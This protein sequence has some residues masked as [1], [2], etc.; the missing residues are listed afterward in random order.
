MT[1]H[2]R[3]ESVGFLLALAQV[4]ERIALFP[5]KK[6]QFSTVDT[7]KMKVIFTPER[8]TFQ[9]ILGNKFSNVR[10]AFIFGF[11]EVHS[12]SA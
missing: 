12:T 11:L 4:A 10:P 1:S 8:L 2:N 3:N 9:G 7:L 5:E 6:T